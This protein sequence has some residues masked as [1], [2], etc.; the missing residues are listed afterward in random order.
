MDPIETPDFSAPAD[1]VA[2]SAASDPV[3]ISADP[4]RVLLDL[5]IEP[6]HRLAAMIEPLARELLLQLDPRDAS[7]KMLV[8]QMIST[9][10]RAMFLSRYANRQKHPKWFALYSQQCDRAMDL[11]RKQM[12]SLSEYRRPRR[13]T[14]N[15]IRTAN[16]AGQQVVIAAAPAS[17]AASPTESPGAVRGD[18]PGNPP[19][20]RA[21]I[22]SEDAHVQSTAAP[23]KTAAVSPV[24]RRK[25][26]PAR[27]DPKNKAV[28]T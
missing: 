13:T 12:Q 21:N 1:S 4:L 18:W 11:Y 25:G 23:S 20:A 16:I 17:S 7:E 14:F 27:R 28:G 24:A 15:A 10:S 22:E 26:R 5:A 6:D 8:T 2:G 19:V 3:A 9:F